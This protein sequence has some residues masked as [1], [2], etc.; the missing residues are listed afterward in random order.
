[1]VQHFLL[2]FLLSCFLGGIAIAHEENPG[3]S[4]GSNSATKTWIAFN[5]GYSLASAK[6][7][8]EWK[9]RELPSIEEAEALHEEIKNSFGNAGCIWTRNP[10]GDAEFTQTVFSFNGIDGGPGKMYGKPGYWRGTNCKLLCVVPSKTAKLNPNGFPEH[11]RI[12][13]FSAT[14]HKRSLKD[15]EDRCKDKGYRLPNFDEVNLLYSDI[16][17]S[18]DNKGCIWT[19]NKSGDREN[20]QTVF[21]LDGVAD[22]TEKRASK[23]VAGADLVNA[24]DGP[25]TPCKTLCVRTA[26]GEFLKTAIK[27]GYYHFQKDNAVWSVHVD[28]QKDYYEISIPRV[29]YLRPD[30]KISFTW[31]PMGSQPIRLYMGDNSAVDSFVPRY[32]YIPEYTRDVKK[33]Q[34]NEYEFRSNRYPD[35]TEAKLVVDKQGHLH[36]SWKG[37]RLNSSQPDE[38]LFEF[39]SEELILGEK[40]L[41]AGGASL[42]DLNG[43]VPGIRFEEMPKK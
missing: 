21:S 6:E 15:A 18:F 22:G 32:S 8:C 40:K 28:D 5:T 38:T 27:P 30:G 2:S 4:R 41:E 9:G 31:N 16:K 23:T 42:K 13:W 33:N 24:F 14:T 17:D 20:P 34:M 39:A 29:E 3:G 37:K 10:S 26:E 11:P 25:P 43:K 7:Q 12:S 36:L 19:R 35:E 1:M